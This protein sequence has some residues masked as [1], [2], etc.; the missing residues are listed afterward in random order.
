MATKKWFVRDGNDELGPLGP[1][2]LRKLVRSGR[3]QPDT[4]VRREDQDT[5]VRAGNVRGLFEQP[6]PAAAPPDP[7]IVH[8]PF[9][10]LRAPGIAAAIG[11]V[12]WI[13]LA[14]YGTL[15][16]LQQHAIATEIA[17]G[18]V[19]PLSDAAT[20]ILGI[21]T[22]PVAIVLLVT[23]PLFVWWL[24]S[25]RT[26]VPHLISARMRFAPSWTI[27][28]WLVPLLNLW[29]PYEVVDEIDWRSAEAAA[30]GDASVGAQ[31]SLLVPWWVATLLAAGVFVRTEF[32]GTDTAQALIVVANE[33]LFA[34]AVLV[35]A[36]A[37]ATAVV[38]RI[39]SLQERAHA[40]HAG[41]VQVHRNRT[42]HHHGAATG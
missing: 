7:S 42:R 22:I 11:M 12:A 2:G 33:R 8:G 25:A 19:R 29:R 21:G 34:S 28:G 6:P 15:T 27:G 5:A 32:V 14:A 35:I 13:A 26:N 16:A 31:R 20:P 18:T 37:L 17:N 36:A 3:I 24:W 1:N 39:T 38:W 9:T 40:R 23:G 4:P 10:S 41:P 30:D